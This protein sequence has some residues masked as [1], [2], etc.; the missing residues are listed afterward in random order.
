MT[1]RYRSFKSE[2]AKRP[3]LRR[4]HRDNVQDHPLRLVTALAEGFGNF[5]ALGILQAFLHRSFGAHL[6]AQLARERFDFDPLQQFLD[7]LSAHHGLKAAGAMFLVK[8]AILGFVLDHFVVLDGG[9]ASFDHHIGFE[10]EHRLKVAQRDIEDVPD[11]AGQSFEEPDVRAGRSQLNVAQPLAAN[12]GERYFHAALVANH[13][14]VF[15]ALVLAAE[16]LP[17]SDRTEN[18]GAKQTVTLRLEG[19]VVD[20]LRLGDFTVRP[21]TNLFRRSQADADGVEVGDGVSEIKWTRAVQIV[22]LPCEPSRW[23]LQGLAAHSRP[24]AAP[25]NFFFAGCRLLRK[26]WRRL[27]RS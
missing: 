2:V 14:A 10:V 20:R 25:G 13:A 24:P 6:L 23:K 8:F 12:F 1:R 17:I 5:Q 19:T 26:R 16:T 22:L 27:P 21:A 11:A 9:L 15:H 4:D 7:G 18:P 3:K